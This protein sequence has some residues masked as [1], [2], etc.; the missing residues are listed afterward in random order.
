MRKILLLP[1]LLLSTLHV[2]AGETN[3]QANVTG[4]PTVG[5]L[6]PHFG[7]GGSPNATIPANHRMIAKA[8]MKYKDGNFVSID[9]VTYQYSN[10]RGSV[11]N[12]DNINNDE[13]VLFDMSTT[14]SFNTTSG[15]YENSR[16][17]VQ[18]FTDN[19]VRELIYKKWHTITSAWKNSERYLYTYDNNGKMH[20]SVLQLWYSLQWTQDINSVLSYDQN[21]NVVQMNSTTYTIDFVYDQDNNLVMIEDKTWSQSG[22]WS[23][24]ERK[25]YTYT[26]DDV[27]EYVL[28]KWVN[29]AWVNDKK[30]E[31]TYDAND[32]V[33]LA[34]E[35]SWG[36]AAWQKVT[37]EDYTYDVNDNMLVQT[38]KNW[39]AGAGAFVNR[40]REVRT[41]NKHNLITDITSFSWNGSSWVHADDDIIIRY[42]YEA[43]FPTNVNTVAINTQM[44]IYPVPATDNI[45]VSFGFNSGQDFSVV[46]A[47]MTGKVV[48]TDQVTATAVYDKVI[49]VHNIPSGTYLLR[50]NGANGI[51]M[52]GKLA[53][54]H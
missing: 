45:H 46:V 20:S 35:Y 24:N 6:F 37:R 53:V 11:P 5:G 33:I 32:N 12:P 48:Y 1:A 17:R 52:T 15:Q 23:N 21:N 31:Y 44:T 18:Y 16:Q 47:D 50:V 4:T 14:Y 40:S 9:S 38:V 8:Y 49:P 43:Y 2:F 27:S 30:W 54:V 41:Y 34:T 39:D 42:Y 7:L 36:V 51:N 22:G 10:G 28:E 13:H 25:K 19:K 26:N 29:G 3:T